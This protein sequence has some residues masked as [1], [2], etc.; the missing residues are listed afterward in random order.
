MVSEV[1]ADPFVVS[2]VCRPPFVVS[3]SNHGAP[4]TRSGRTECAD[5]FMVGMSTNLMH[6]TR[7]YVDIPDLVNTAR[8]YQALLLKR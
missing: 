5:P 6:T 8:F 7:E 4:S 3:L 2:R 1:R